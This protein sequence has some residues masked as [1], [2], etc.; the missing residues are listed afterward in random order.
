MYRF[1]KSGMVV[2]AYGGLEATR[3]LVLATNA[4]RRTQILE[5]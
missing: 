2:R 4:A 5:T 1:G 3:T